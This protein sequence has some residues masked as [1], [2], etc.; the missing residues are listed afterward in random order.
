MH[1]PLNYGAILQTYSL[2][3]YL[4]SLSLKVFVINYR[5]DYIVS[6]Q[7]LYYVGNEKFKKNILTKIAYC[8]FKAPSKLYRRRMFRI[9]AN[10]ELNLTDEYRTYN[11]ICDA[12]LSAD[13]FFCG[14]DQIWNVVSG[15]YK[16]PAYFLEFVSDNAIKISYAASGN[17]PLVKEV[18][19]ISFPMIN[20]INHVSMREDST[21]TDIQPFI[22]RTISHVCDPVFLTSQIDWTLLYNKHNINKT[23][24]K[25][26]LV[27]PMGNGLENTIKQAYQLSEQ[28]KLPLYMI[29]ASKR[30]DPRADKQFIVDPYNF[31]SYIDRAEY[32]ITNSFHGTS[33]SIIFKK[34]FWTCVAEGSNQRITSLLIKVGLQS[35]LLSGNMN[36]NINERIDY[37]STEQPLSLFISQSKEFIKQSVHE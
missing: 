26:I 11:D 17:L 22:K 21:I 33:F 12:K 1:C 20:R 31:L 13:F 34:Q 25:Y 3:K 23:K 19:D 5:P 15:S 27:Y 10:H 29:S 7:K 28:T 2:Q 37:T 24:E 16:D 9:F 8:L 14:S 35:R 36:L 6:D 18:K 4:E 32:V 30:K